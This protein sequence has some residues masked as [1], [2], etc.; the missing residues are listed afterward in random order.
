VFSVETSRLA[1]FRMIIGVSLPAN[2]PAGFSLMFST[3]PVYDPAHG[4]IYALNGSSVFADGV[5]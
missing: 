1:F 3:V 2:A 4:A 5:D